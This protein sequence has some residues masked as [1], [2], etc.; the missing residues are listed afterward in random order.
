MVDPDIGLYYYNARWCDPDLGRFIFEDLVADLN[1]PNL[2]S[3]CGNNPINRIDPTGKFWWVFAL[4]G[5]LDSY[6]CGGDFMQGFVMGAVTG[7]IGAGVGA[8][9]NGTAWG[10]ALAKTSTVGFNAVSGAISGG[11]TGELFGEGFGKGA[12]FG[13][14]AGAINVGV[15]KRYG[16]FASK[17]TFNKVLINGLK[18]GLNGLTRG[19]DFLEGFAYGF[20][21]GYAYEYVND[22]ASLPVSDINPND[23]IDNVDIPPAESAEM[24]EH[25]YKGK[26]GESIPSGEWTLLKV[27]DE[28]GLQMGIYGK[29]GANGKMEYAIVNAGTKPTSIKDWVNN[30]KAFFGKSPDIRRS[31]EIA[32]NF[33]R[34]NPDSKI[35]CIGHSKGGA[36]AICNAI[37]INSNAIVFNPA[38]FNPGDYTDNSAYSGTITAFIVKGEIL[39]NLFHWY[40]RPTNNIIYLPSQSWSSISNHVMGSVRKAIDEWQGR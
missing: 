9:L 6:L 4:F 40:P 36:E 30:V 5:G 34:Q 37:E 8:A 22:L 18:G 32:K 33:A 15:D 19:K 28:K 20:T 23:I 29:I 2:Y 39:T 1:N 31:M 16:D 17:S 11:I 35:T 13:A 14:V 7:A 27:Y 26:V 12:V 38:P 25:V 3:Y 10:A 21:Y 24:A